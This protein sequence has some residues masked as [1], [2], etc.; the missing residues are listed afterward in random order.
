MISVVIGR[1]LLQRLLRSPSVFLSHRLN[2]RHEVV[3]YFLFRDTADGGVWCI[4]TD[5][6]QIIENREERNLSELGDARDEDETLVFVLFFQDGKHGLVDGCA[7]IML[8]SLP[9]MLQWRII[10]IEEDNRLF[11]CL[12]KHRF[13]DVLETYG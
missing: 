6:A 4:K 9:G 10:L 5:V 2:L 7:G 13:D 11:S 3:G 1:E 8:R 12:L